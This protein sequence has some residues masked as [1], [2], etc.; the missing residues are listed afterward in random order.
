MQFNEGFLW[1]VP[2]NG[3][4]AS[5]ALLISVAARFGDEVYVGGAEN[6][7][8]FPK[9]DRPKTVTY[10]LRVR[11]AVYKVVNVS[12][13]VF[14]RASF[15]DT[16]GLAKLKA[17]VIASL[18]EMFAILVDASTIDPTG[19][20]T[21]LVPNPRIDFGYYLKDSDGNPS[22][23]LPYSDIYDAVGD[24][25]G[26]LRVQAGPDGV[27]VNGVQGDV[28]L[29]LK[30]FPTLGTVTVIDARTGFVL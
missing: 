16:A 4:T 1:I 14:P 17:N 8:M 9:G 10:Q 28:Q 25:D 19:E 26:V 5:D 2:T 30:E 27:L 24:A 11:S 22:A 6:P 20:T 3:G 12:T 13:R 18:A 23:I 7:T 15:A 29:A 21:G